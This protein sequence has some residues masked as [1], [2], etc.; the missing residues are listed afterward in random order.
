MFFG[1]GP[2]ECAGILGADFVLYNHR[3]SR[4]DEI[5]AVGT[6]QDHVQVSGLQAGFLQGG[7]SSLNCQVRRTPV[8]WS[9]PVGLDAGGLAK[10]VDDFAKLL[11]MDA[12][13]R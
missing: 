11:R 6:K 2:P 10:F 7:A 3:S 13:V 12:F 8:F 9:I 1:G 5:P 4:G